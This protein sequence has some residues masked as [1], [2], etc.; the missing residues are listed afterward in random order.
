M[1]RLQTEEE[2]ETAKWSGKNSDGGEE[3][4]DSGWEDGKIR[5]RSRRRVPRFKLGIF[6][7]FS[8][9]Q[10]SKMYSKWVLEMQD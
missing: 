5:P 9:E 4:L 10:Y 7:P 6:V 3:P 8:G 1:D 2:G